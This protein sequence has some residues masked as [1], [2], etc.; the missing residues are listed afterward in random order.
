MSAP[1]APSG[2]GSPQEEPRSRLLM[3]GLRL[4][5]QHGYSKTRTRELAEAAQ[6]N[7]AAISYYF[8][9]KAG[10]YA[11]V[12]LEPMGGAPQAE[13]ARFSNLALSLADALAGFYAGF[14]EPLKQG[15]K[16]RLCMKLHFREMLEPTGLWPC[17]AAHGI[18][19]L[20]DGLV[21]LLGR[22]LGVPE[23][24]CAADA[25]L[26]RLALSLAALGVHLHVGYEMAEVIT[27]GLMAGPEQINLWSERLVMFGLAMVCAEA[28]R[29]GVPVKPGTVGARP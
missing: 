2:E 19:P 23:A 18:K 13:L 3:A 20:H 28:A 29:R 9:D 26:Q 24:D 15:D 4:F 6:V 5:A 10:L 8:G 17:D 12:F 14:L 16:V 11:A 7:V 25:D 27:P 22:H 21:A 1:T